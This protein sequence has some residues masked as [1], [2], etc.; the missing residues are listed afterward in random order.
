MKAEGIVSIRT[1]L[2]VCGA[3]VSFLLPAGRA[4]GQSSTAGPLPAAQP[5]D[6]PPAAQAP[7]QSSS[8]KPNLAGTW[9]LNKDQSDDPR[10]K[11]HAAMQ[12]GGGNG[13]PGGGGGGGGYGGGWNR[14]EGGG[15]GG[16]GEGRGQGGGMMNDLS[17]LTITQ[18]DTSV[19]VTGE[20]GR[21]LAVYSAKSANGS[22]TGSSANSGADS[23]G[24]EEGYTPPQ[25][26]WQGSQLVAVQQQRAGTVTRTFEMSSD[27]KQ[28]YVT[29]KMDSQ[30]FS[31]PVTF[32]LVYDPAKS[33]SGTQ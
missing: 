1:I 19:K 2:A 9:T 25:A 31:Q 10:Q 13:G 14:G 32:R 23:S 4:A 22:D 26:Q 33:T 29:T 5:S 15:G 21:V 11:M 8:A 30:R 7:A 6:Q 20:S 27:G 12:N 17:Q 28:L 3:S 24:N 16:R 18:T